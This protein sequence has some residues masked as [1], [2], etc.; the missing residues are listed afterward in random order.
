MLADSLM[1]MGLLGVIVLAVAMGMLCRRAHEFTARVM[2]DGMPGDVYSLYVLS[3]VSTLLLKYRS[4]V[5]DALQSFVSFSV[6]F[7]FV[8]F[9]G[10]LTLDRRVGAISVLR[11][12][13]KRYDNSRPGHIAE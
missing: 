6:L 2:R 12:Q 4:G 13:N 10:Y 1:A 3:V 7:W 5:G 9:L 11:A 8:A